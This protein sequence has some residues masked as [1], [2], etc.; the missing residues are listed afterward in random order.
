M[1]QEIISSKQ[2]GKK[3]L[4]AITIVTFVSIALLL[5]ACQSPESKI[6]NVLK[7]KDSVSE[8]LEKNISSSEWNSLKED[9]RKKI[10]EALFSRD[11]TS[12]NYF[13]DIT[14]VLDRYEV[15]LSEFKYGLDVA[16]FKHPEYE[17]NEGSFYYDEQHR[18]DLDEIVNHEL[19]N[20]EYLGDF[21]VTQKNTETYTV[22]KRGTVFNN[23]GTADSVILGTETRTNSGDLVYCCNHM[24]FIPS[25][26]INENG[27]SDYYIY[28][29][30]NTLI[31]VDLTSLSIE[32]D[33]KFDS[34]G[35]GH[36]SKGY[37]LRLF[38]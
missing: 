15:K 23:D 2:L 16:G 4:L 9:S 21:A 34:T 20:W 8:E 30:D 38:E 22:E 33:T 18:S 26:K 32:S 13:E 6:D 35:A 36:R 1:N 25:S 7:N 27:V 12:E 28:N 11:I 5:T 29:K 3:T 31:T 24:S 17:T 10:I 14:S 19:D 37:K